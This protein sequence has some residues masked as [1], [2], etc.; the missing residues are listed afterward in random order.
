MAASLI[1][2]VQ[3]GAIAFGRKVIFESLAFNIHDGDRICLVGRN[4]SGKTTLMNVITGDNIRRSGATSL[5]EA[6][7]LAP[8]LEVARVNSQTYNISSRGMI[9]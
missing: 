3:D 9:V 5:A 2:S 8:N 4:G 1:L 7:R 6:L